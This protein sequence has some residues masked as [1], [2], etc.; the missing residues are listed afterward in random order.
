M[1][2]LN[3]EA[4]FERQGEGYV[5]RLTP[6]SAGYAISQAQK[7]LLGVGWQRIDRHS[8]IEA[9]LAV[10]LIV[11][12]FLA[13]LLRS[14]TPGLWILALSTLTLA[15]LTLH[16]LRQRRRLL[17]RTVGDRPPDLPRLPVWR[18]LWQPRPPLVAERFA[19]PVLRVTMVLLVLLLVGGDALALFVIAAAD[20]PAQQSNLDA[21]PSLRFWPA[22]LLF[23][24]VMVVMI[25]LLGFESR[26]L[27]RRRQ[28]T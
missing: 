28:G 20:A 2:L 23:N 1:G 22:L 3:Q 7:D 6:F 5:V 12:L 10:A 13:G 16:S 11:S 26:R 8:S 14:E 17:E 4:F 19:V 9:L 25:A 18:A 24:L 15:L 21:L 27:R